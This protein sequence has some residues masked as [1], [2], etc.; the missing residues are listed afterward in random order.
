MSSSPLDSARARLA[1]AAAE[2][3]EAATDAR[4]EGATAAADRAAAAADIA[5]FAATAD[6]DARA[7]CRLAELVESVAFESRHASAAHWAA[8]A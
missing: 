8:R 3:A 4:K 2:A 7:L 1:T 5:R 6:L